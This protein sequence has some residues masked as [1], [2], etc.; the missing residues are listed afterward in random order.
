MDVRLIDET[1]VDAYQVLLESS[2]GS[3][4]D[5]TELGVWRPLVETERTHGAFDGG[6]LV[7]SA[8][9]FTFDMTVPGGP[10]PCAGVTGVSVAPPRTA[11]RAP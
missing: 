11:G 5:P 10:R 7:G 2:F 8:A 3:D 6:T 1:E 9:V 4:P